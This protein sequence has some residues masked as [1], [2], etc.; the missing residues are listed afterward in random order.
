[1]VGSVIATEIV[2]AW[3]IVTTLFVP[4]SMMLVLLPF[5]GVVLN[6]TS[7][8]LYGTVPELAP[9]GDTARAFALFY[10]SVIGAGAFAPIA[11]GAI[12]DH[13]S[14]SFGVISSGVTALLTVPLILMLRPA[15]VA[16][17]AGV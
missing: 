7:S 3:L 11:Y 6:G 4:L 5:L 12:A 2:T 15:L 14:Q 1:V 10:T 17:G 8:V 13:S 9:K 16:R